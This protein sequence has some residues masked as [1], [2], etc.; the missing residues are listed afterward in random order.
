M[1]EGNNIFDQIAAL[2][3][4][5]GFDTPKNHW[6]EMKSND[7]ST[8]KHNT[9]NKETSHQETNKPTNTKT[10]ESNSCVP[11][12]KVIVKTISIANATAAGTTPTQHDLGNQY[13][14]LLGYFIINNSLGGLT[15]AQIKVGLSDNNRTILDP[16]GLE[17]HNVS[18]SVPIKD[19]FNKEEC[20]SLSDGKVTTNTVTSA[21]TTSALELQV[22][23][24]V[25]KPQ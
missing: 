15:T 1:T 6:P 10:M 13:K 16:V 8:L 21:I 23:F 17:Y 5:G 11:Q 7:P 4:N 24:L 22:L 25:E 3:N 9:P 12:T 18:T 2:K 14:K 19:R 20:I